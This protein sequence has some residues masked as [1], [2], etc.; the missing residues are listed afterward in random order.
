MK[1]RRLLLLSVLVYA[2]LI[3]GLASANGVIIASS[4]PLVIHLT[5]AL[6]Y[7]PQNLQLHVNRTL[8]TDR[9]SQGVPV[10][11]TVSI[12]NRGSHLEEVVVEDVLPDNLNVMEGTPCVRVEMSPGQSVNLEYTVRG[13]RGR[14]A[15]RDIKVRASDRLGLF[16]RQAV[17]HAPA[18]LIILPR[19]TWLRRVSIRPLQTHGYA[20]P[21]P[22]RSGGSGV[23]FFGVREY[24]LGDPMRWINWRLSA[25]HPHAFFTNEF[26]QE[27]IADVGLILDARQRSEVRVN[28]QSLFEHGVSATASLANVFLNDGNRVGLL[29]YGGFLDWVFPGYGKMQRERI[30]Q[31]LA[32]AEPGESM[33]FDRLDFIPTRFFPA[34]SQI[35]LVSPLWEEDLPILIRLRARGYQLLVISQDPVSF[36]TKVLGSDPMASLATRIARLERTLLIR[37]GHQIGIQ[38]VNWQVDQPFDH[39]VH[40]TLGRIPLWFRAVGLGLRG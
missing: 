21:V 16:H 27:R 33:I 28:G 9:V 6:I 29:V 40:A 1:V 32:R 19:V 34:R 14:Y 12:I 5:A 4:I 37:K 26:E 38:I 36:E 30:L 8:S 18:H 11:V 22:A 35:V 31:A 15:F 25:R 3:L 10:T 39:A 7:A 2:L 23:D 24:Q 20:G 13:V 17:L